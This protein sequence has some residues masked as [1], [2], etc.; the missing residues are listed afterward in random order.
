M[1]PLALDKFK[2]GVAD[3][4]DRRSR[5][6]DQGQWH[7]QICD[8][9][10]EYARIGAGQT[11]LDI[12]TGTGYLAI[13]SAQ[14][15]GDQGHVT[16]VDISPGM[17][18]QAQRKIQRLG[19]SNVVVQ[20][21][22]AEALDYPSHHFDVILCA[23]TFPWMTDKAATLRLW[24]QLLK[25]RGRIA[26]HTPA[27]TAYIGAVVLRRVLAEYGLELEPS[28][29]LGSIEQCRQLFEKAGFEAV[30]IYTEQHG[31]Y[32]T[33]DQAKA[34]WESVVVNPSITAPK[35]VGDGRSRFSATELGKIK[36]E[37]YAELEALQTEQGLWNDL[38]TVYI[39]AD[40]PEP[41]CG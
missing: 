7:P 10:L 36:A 41:Y 37:L 12:G 40:K 27:D 28:N 34:I 8:R 9:L 11:V 18:Q 20:R 29:R 3:F 5:S 38:T 1:K 22:D 6:Y 16:G 32:T 30:E 14:R 4:Y 19:L 31:S 26:V 17:L 39:L 13:A 15:V 23:H 2:Q 35:V 21:A 25:P 33:L 24:Y